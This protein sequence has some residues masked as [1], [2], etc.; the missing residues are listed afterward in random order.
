M[1][2][3]SDAAD[4]LGLTLPRRSEV[5]FGIVAVAAVII[6]SNALSLSLI[7]I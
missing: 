5:V 2:A 3:G 1:R 6:A 4:Y 7:H